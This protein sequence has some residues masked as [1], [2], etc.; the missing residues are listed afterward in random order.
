MIVS[1]RADKYTWAKPDFVML[2]SE[3]LIIEKDLSGKLTYPCR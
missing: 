3:R 2:K 1:A